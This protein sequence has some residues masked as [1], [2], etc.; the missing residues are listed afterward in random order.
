MGQAV[1]TAA[2]GCIRTGLTPREYGRKHIKE[3]QRQLVKDDQ[4]IIGMK[5]ED[6]ANLAAKGTATAT[7]TDKGSPAANAIDG[8]SRTL[9]KE[10]SR[11]WISDP[12]A[13]L[14]Q[15]VDV[16][17]ASPAEISEVRVVFD[18]DFYIYPKW[19]KHTVPSTL[20]K[21]YTIEV[22][23]ENGKWVKV[24]DVKGNAKRM[25]V[26]AFPVRTAKAVRVAVSGTWGDPSARVFEV[27]CYR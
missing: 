20:A 27:K 17:F 10:A 24:A 1:G 25:A 8:F 15:S 22:L 16:A 11:S 18:S 9:P 3:L 23:G 6:P 2:A 5:D 19:V 13:N 21:D 14:P 26:H 4:Y 7:S 12:K